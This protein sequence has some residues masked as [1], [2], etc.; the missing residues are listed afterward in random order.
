LPEPAGQ[1][2]YRSSQE[3]QLRREFVDTFKQCPI[4]DIDIL[5][6]L[7]LFINSKNLSRMLFMQHIYE[8]IVEVPGIVIEFGTR[9]GQ[10]MALFSALRGIYE[11]F[12]RHRKI[13]AFDTFAGFPT[14]AIGSQDNTGSPIIRPGGLATSQ[15]YGNYLETVMNYHEQDNPLGHIKKFEIRQGDASDETRKYLEEFP[16]TIVSLAYF[17]LDIYEP[18]RN[19]LQLIREHLVKG[20][21]LAFDELNDRDCPGETVALAEVFGLNNI[22]L[23]RWRHA[24]RTAYF[25]VE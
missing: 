11:P 10:N 14:E 19:C 8:Q 17:D 4:P 18:T 25:V 23:R 15:G 24:A 3:D 5:N 2:L 13:V 6:N 21:I 9:W 12:N 1:E 7:G 22:R 16:E 20:S